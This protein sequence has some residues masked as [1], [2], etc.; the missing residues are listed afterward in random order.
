[1]QGK[2]CIVNGGSAPNVD[3]FLGLDRRPFC[4]E[5]HQCKL[6]NKDPID[7]FA[8]REK[9]V[10]NLDFFILFTSRVLDI[11]LPRN[12]GVVDK[13]NW[14]TYFGPFAGRALIYATTGALDINNATLRDLR[15]ME[16]VGLIKA[17]TIISERSKRKF[18]DLEEA[19]KRLKDSGV[20]KVVLS[21]F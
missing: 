15:R 6:V 21:R 3:S 4:T 20:G 18:K 19:K 7:Y 8:E 9:A 14:N 2:H 13:N 11:T 10:S 1:M 12:S 17:E 16:G 5:V